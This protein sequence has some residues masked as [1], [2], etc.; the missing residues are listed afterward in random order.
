MEKEQ[1]LEI[2]K[3]KKVVVGEMEKEKI[4]KSCW[5]ANLVA[6]IVSNIFAVILGFNGLFAGLYAVYS[7][8]LV[9]SSVFYFCQYFVA[10]RTWYIL[11]SAVLYSIGAVVTITFFILFT[12]GVV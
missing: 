5:I 1:I 4:N 2:V 11:I 9:W 8:C 10:K 7:V 12:I 3:N 6:V